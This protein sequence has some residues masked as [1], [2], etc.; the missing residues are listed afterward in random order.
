MLYIKPNR[1]IWQFCEN[2]DFDFSNLATR[3]AREHISLA[4]LKKN[5]AKKKRRKSTGS[6]LSFA[7]SLPLQYLSFAL[8]LCLHAPAALQQANPNPP[9]SIFFWFFFSPIV[10]SHNL[11]LLESPDPLKVLL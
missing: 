4:I 3:K 5:L 1:E 10:S 6:E 9:T 8:A 7:S 2:F 11:L